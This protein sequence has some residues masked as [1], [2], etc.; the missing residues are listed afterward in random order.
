MTEHTK[1]PWFVRYCDDDKHMCMTVI[2]STDHGP[3]NTS[4]YAEEPDTVAIVFHQGDPGVSNDIEDFGDANARRIVACV[5]ACKR[6]S[7]EL[8]EAA[9]ACGGITADPTDDL[10]KTQKQRDMLQSQANALHQVAGALEFKA[11][12]DV[13][14]APWAVAGLVR[15]RDELLAALTRAERK[16]TAY[17]GVCSGDKELTDAVLPMARSAIAKVKK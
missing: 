6:F 12:D 14:R 7:T 13:T 9:A 15:Q 11:G 2:S 3:S 10:L 4:Q 5:N 8:L 1:E 16:L 17:V